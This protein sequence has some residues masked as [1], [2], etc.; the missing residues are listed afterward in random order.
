[1]GVGAN[2]S[3]PTGR[4]AIRVVER[5]VQREYIEVHSALE[6]EIQS[7]VWLA[8]FKTVARDSVSRVGSIP[9][10]LRLFSES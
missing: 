1:M 3:R 8:V 7:L 5:N 9:A 4:L 10:S 6:G 2:P